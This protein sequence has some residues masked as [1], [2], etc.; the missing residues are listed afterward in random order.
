[1][2]LPPN[3]FA[4]DFDDHDDIQSLARVALVGPSGSGKTYTGLELVSEFAR[5]A[6]GTF[7]VIDTERGKSR[8]YRRFFGRFPCM[9]LTDHDPRN[10][11]QAIKL[12]E[13][14]GHT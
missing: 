11:L 14:H 6:G 8:L 2:P 1:M 4:F 10:Y 7:A 12:A 5:A 9:N 13:R 3:K